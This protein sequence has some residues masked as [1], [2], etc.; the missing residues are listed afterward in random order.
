MSLIPLPHKVYVSRPD[1][2]DDWGILVKGT[3]STEYKARIKY[4]IED[5]VAGKTTGQPVVNTIPTGS[6]ILEVSA[7]VTHD[8]FIVFTA[9]NGKTY[10]VSPKTIKPISDYNAKPMY[11]KVTF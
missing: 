7:E 6:M 11:W 9:N 2:L 3:E 1:R 8:D 4:S 5:R 10:E